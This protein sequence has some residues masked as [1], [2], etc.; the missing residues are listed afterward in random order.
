MNHRKM[1]LF[2]DSF[3]SAHSL[4]FWEWIIIISAYNNAIW[5]KSS[6]SIIFVLFISS[7][8][9]CCSHLSHKTVLGS[10][11]RSSRRRNGS[12]PPCRCHCVGRG[13]IG[14]VWATLWSMRAS[15]PLP[16]GPQLVVGYLCFAR[17]QTGPWCSPHNRSSTKPS[18][19]EEEVTSVEL[20]LE[21]I[22]GKV[23]CHIPL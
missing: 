10:P 20:W 8:L 16:S 18:T 17:Q 19:P 2:S 11:S 14:T 5:Q 9:P 3:K 7:L 23:F 12:S 15:P 6:K 1:L 22:S 21:G 13:W 4:L